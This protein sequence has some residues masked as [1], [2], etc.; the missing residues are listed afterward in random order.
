VTKGDFGRQS[1]SDGAELM[2]RQ[3]HP[4]WVDD[5]L[6][7]AFRPTK[8]DAKMLSVAQG[9]KISAEAAFVRHTEMLGLRSAGTW[10]VNVGEVTAANLKCFADPEP[11][12]PSHAFIDFSD[13]SR[14]KPEAKS[15][16]LTVHAQRRGCLHS[17][18][19]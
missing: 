8:K 17:R 11:D 9:S 12:D 14:R 13:I 5:G 7:S 10:G 3:V 16:L 19:S 6:P 2:Y 18:I 1:L 4:N 15:Q